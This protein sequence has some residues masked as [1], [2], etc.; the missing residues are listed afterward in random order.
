VSRDGW[1]DVSFPKMVRRA[2]FEVFW[3]VVL[4]IKGVVF[5]NFLC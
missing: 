1:M 2:N 5:V 3:W 4:Y